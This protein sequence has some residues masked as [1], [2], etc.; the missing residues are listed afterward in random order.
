MQRRC[1]KTVNDD[2]KLLA[3]AHE[4]F[5]AW[6]LFCDM[7]VQSGL[8][9]CGELQ[10]TEHQFLISVAREIMQSIASHQI[11]SAAAL[12][13]P[14]VATPANYGLVSSGDMETLMQAVYRT[15]GK[16]HLKKFFQAGSL[17]YRLRLSWH[18]QHPHFPVRLSAA[19]R[20]SPFCLLCGA[21]RA[22]FG[23][24]VCKV[25]LCLAEDPHCFR[26]FHDPQYGARR[27]LS[28]SI[29][30][31][32]VWIQD[33]IGRWCCNACTWPRLATG[34]SRGTYRWLGL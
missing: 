20:D 23:C 19:T 18:A 26:L 22:M 12:L 21:V 7:H 17:E 27:S 9:G 1:G 32:I 16:Y 5:S 25:R 13:R 2:A 3:S 30:C 24:A 33:N 15:S 8:I 34:W 11:N 31:T 4:F 10:T 28:C 29:T 6:R 14:I